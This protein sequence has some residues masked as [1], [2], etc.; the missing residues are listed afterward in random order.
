MLV[1]H[2]ITL[3]VLHY[4]VRGHRSAKQRKLFGAAG[5][6]AKVEML[7]WVQ[8]VVRYLTAM[9]G[10]DDMQIPTTP[11]TNLT[12]DWRSGAVLEALI[13][14]LGPPCLPETSINNPLDLARMCIANAG[15]NGNPLPVL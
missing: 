9:S 4:D 15:Q 12:S 3:P 10:D 6:S 7:A 13:R 11:V 5:S 14:A 1:C 2:A 8:S